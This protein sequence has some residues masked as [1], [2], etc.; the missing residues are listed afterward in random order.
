MLWQCWKLD[1]VSLK[2]KYV[3]E[4]PALNFGAIYCMN[5]NHLILTNIVFE[6]PTHSTHCYSSYHACSSSMCSSILA[7]IS[8]LLPMDEACISKTN[9]NCY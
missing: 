7:R 6:G 8:L 9:I 3:A 5:V 1:M 2:S 4:D